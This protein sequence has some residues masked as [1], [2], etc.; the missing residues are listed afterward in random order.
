MSLKT[1]LKFIILKESAKQARLSNAPTR[2]IQSN[3]QLTPTKKEVRPEGVRLIMHLSMIFPYLFTLSHSPTLAHRS[4]LQL[5]WQSGHFHFERGD[6]L[7]L[8]Q[9]SQPLLYWTVRFARWQPLGGTPQHPFELLASGREV[10]H[11]NILRGDG[12]EHHSQ[13]LSCLPLR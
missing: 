10:P 4:P 8:H 12:L 9:Q 7:R 1:G 11:H 3:I 2:F 6:S 13:L 5:R